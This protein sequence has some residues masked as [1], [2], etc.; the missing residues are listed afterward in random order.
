MT[1]TTRDE[2]LRARIVAAL[3][4]LHLA[5]TDDSGAHTGHPGAA[6][7]A[8]HYTVVVVSARFAGLPLVAR[9][10]L[11]YDAVGDLMPN[12][13]HALAITAYAPDEWGG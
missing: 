6:G 9:H 2:R 3:A 1:A 13:V 10:R 7:G 8:G 12:E 4:P 11:V 5:L